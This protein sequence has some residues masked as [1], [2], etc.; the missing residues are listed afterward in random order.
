[1]NRITQT[2]SFLTFYILEPM[3]SAWSVL[4]MWPT[5]VCEI[6]FLNEKPKMKSLIQNVKQFSLLNK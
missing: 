5:R 6:E 2:F 3:S 1:M 4:K